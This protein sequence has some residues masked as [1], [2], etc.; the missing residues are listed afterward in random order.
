MS[1]QFNERLQ[2]ALSRSGMTQ[3]ELAA[4]AGVTEA[5]ISHYLKGDRLPRFAVAVKL[6]EALN[7]TVEELMSGNTEMNFDE[8]YKIVAR[9]AKQLDNNQ[10]VA[11]VKALFEDGK[12]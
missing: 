7:V 8:V 10:K 5:A 2:Q 1:G 6:A 3:K 9:S 12:I 11:L 4:K